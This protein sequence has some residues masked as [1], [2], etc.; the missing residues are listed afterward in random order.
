MFSYFSEVDR[1]VIR[2]AMYL[3]TKPEK[4]LYTV[5]IMGTVE[6]H[7]LVVRRSAYTIRNAYSRAFAA[8]L[9]MR[10]KIIQ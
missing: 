10:H 2:N 1:F 7:R 3:K 9:M 5:S 4:T 6:G 8:Y